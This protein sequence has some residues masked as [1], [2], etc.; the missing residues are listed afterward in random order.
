MKKKLLII[1]SVLLCVALLSAL[2]LRT[3]ADFG[4]FSG[5]SDFGGGGGSY[6]SGGSSYDSDNDS[7]GGVYVIGGSS[8]GSGRGSG[9]SSPVGLI[10]AAVIIAFVIYSAIKAK[11]RGPIMPGGQKTDDTALHPISELMSADP[12]FSEADITEKV[13]NLY[14]TLQNAWMNRDLEPLRPFLT[15]E[16]FEKSDKQVQAMKQAHRTN[17]VE[18]I[19]VLSAVIRGF[20]PDDVNDNLIV[21]LNTRI[22]DYTTDDS[23]GQIISG[24]NTAEKFMEYEWKLIR[25]KGVVTPDSSDESKDVKTAN[26]PNCGAPIDIAH[27]ARCAY[28]GS[29]LHASEYSWVLSD[30]KG[31][32]QRTNG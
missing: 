10:I 18:Q 29:V 32:S 25:K 8:D 21:Q 13:S 7:G 19:S 22:I 27:S 4:G 23:T 5:N 3:G 14:V 24:S 30:I 31:I 2:A 17:H 26:C 11:K 28:C 12:G 20:I 6:S 1:F 9:G 16:L 15:D